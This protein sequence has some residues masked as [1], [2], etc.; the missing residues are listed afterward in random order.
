MRW[1]LVCGVLAAC[2]ADGPEP[3]VRALVP[4]SGRP[5]QTVEIQGRGFMP[6]G[7]VAFGGEAADVTMWDDGRIRVLIPTIRPGP[8]TVVVTVDGRQ[9]E[10]LRFEVEP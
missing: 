5:G 9:S 4:G 8:T 6:V 2:A 1:A 10:A 3:A 7:F